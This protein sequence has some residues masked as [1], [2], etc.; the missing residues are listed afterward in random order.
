MQ[1]LVEELSPG[2]CEYL[3]G[4]EI[5]DLVFEREI[6][7]TNYK[8]ANVI[9]QADTWDHNLSDIRAHTR[10]DGS[11]YSALNGMGTVDPKKARGLN[12]WR[13]SV[14]RHVLCSEEFKVRA[15]QAEISNF[16]FFEQYTT[17]PKG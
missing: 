5:W 14:T 2:C 8:F 12:L 7:R 15:E 13:D 11:V 16:F 4:P 3:D 6:D 10:R 17:A 1:A 9:K